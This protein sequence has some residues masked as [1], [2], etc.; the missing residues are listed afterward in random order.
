VDP[1]LG[2]TARERRAILRVMLSNGRRLKLT[3]DHEVRSA[4]RLG[5]AMAGRDVYDPYKD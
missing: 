2:V 1:F 4:H 3:G 5:V